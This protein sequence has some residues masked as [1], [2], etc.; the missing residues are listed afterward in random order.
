MLKRRPRADA[1]LEAEQQYAVVLLNEDQLGQF[2]RRPGLKQVNRGYSVPDVHTRYL[3]L[4]R[5]TATAAVVLLVL[6]TG[7]FFYAMKPQPALAS[8]Y[9]WKETPRGA[10]PRYRSQLQRDDRVARKR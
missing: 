1:V 9:P 2:M 10:D 3:K 4:K 6:A 5:Q 8:M 7:G